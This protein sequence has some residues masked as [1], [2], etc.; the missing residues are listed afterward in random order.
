MTV[1]L[2]IDV[3][4]LILPRLR[5]EEERGGISGIGSKISGSGRRRPESG[6]DIVEGPATGEEEAATGLRFIDC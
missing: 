2:F 6:L 1:G 5:G 4:S 3:L